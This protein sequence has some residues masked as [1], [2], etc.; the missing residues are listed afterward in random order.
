MSTKQFKFSVSA[1]NAPYY[2]G[3]DVHKH[4]ITACIYNSGETKSE[5]IKHAVF[6]TDCSGLDNF[7][8]FTR[9]YKPAG[10]VMEATNIYH[11][12]IY[13]LLQEKR[14]KSKWPYLITVVNPAD[15]AG[16]PN[17]QKYDKIDAENLARYYSYGLL[18]AGKP[19]IE[20][21]EDMKSLFRSANRVER[22]RTSLKNRIIK[23]LDQAGI[24][25]EKL[26][27]NTDWTM[28]FLRE[29]IN[30]DGTLGEFFT[31]S[32]KPTL[33][34][35]KYLTKINKNLSK[36]LPYADFSLTRPKR[37]L[38]RQYL[39]DLDFKTA[40][41]VLLSFEIDLILSHEPGLR[42]MAYNLS[43]I[44]GISETS[45]VWIMVEVGNITQ[46]PSLSKF[47]SFCGCCPKIKESGG[48]LYS[49]HINRHS[50]KYLRTIFFNA[51]GVVCKFVKKPSAL[52]DYARY[53]TQKKGYTPGKKL[54]YSIVAAKIARIA[55]IVMK[56]GVP[57]NPYPDDERKL[58]T[59]EVN[60]DLFTV[61][62]KKAIRRAR[63]CL[64]RVQETEGIDMFPDNIKE[65]A[66]QLEDALVLKKKR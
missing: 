41:R 46:F 37:A 30:F 15:A 42:Q 49:A 35:G 54:A 60:G 20:A 18:K 4:E 36:W 50:N 40:R 22:D 34:L 43:T 26:N 14:K 33:P 1:P 9:K 31:T 55:Y 63:N 44:P 25:P 2:C 17:R 59:S 21:L 13:K 10:Y 57:F 52:R 28:A 65:I 23:V 61:C 27:L 48:K 66:K 12:N 53:I 39:G 58:N 38:I 8:K 3:I 7:W 47:L 56:E 45:A 51:A 16:I 29:L 62:E 64:L 5:F 24:R 6:K 32:L 19:I 11:H